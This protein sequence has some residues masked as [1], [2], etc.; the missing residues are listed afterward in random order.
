MTRMSLIDHHGDWR[1]DNRSREKDKPMQ[2]TKI[3]LKVTSLGEAALIGAR[4]P[5]HTVDGKNPASLL[6]HML[7]PRTPDL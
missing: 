7:H 6:L 2:Q 3:L 5:R 1:T 4:S